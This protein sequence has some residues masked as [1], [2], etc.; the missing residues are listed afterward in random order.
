MPGDTP[1][2]LLLSLHHT[3]RFASKSSELKD[4]GYMP[5]SGTAGSYG[6]FIPSCLRNG[7]ADVEHEFVDTVEEGEGGMNGESGIDVYTLSC[8]KQ[9]TSFWQPAV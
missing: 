1:H 2:F 4:P 3:L 6:R 9:I 8:V 7:D 5:S